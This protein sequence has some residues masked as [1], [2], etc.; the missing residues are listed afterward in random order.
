MDIL[1]KMFNNNYDNKIVQNSIKDF[2]KYFDDLT[3]YKPEYKIKYNK[4]NESDSDDKIII[5]RKH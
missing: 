2:K 1:N 4:D 3:I 5:I